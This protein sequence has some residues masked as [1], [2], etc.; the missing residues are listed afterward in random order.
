MPFAVIIPVNTLE[1]G[2]YKLEV[3]SI[4]SLNNKFQRVGTLE[5]Q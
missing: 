2:A 1:P 4:D 5:I 3:A